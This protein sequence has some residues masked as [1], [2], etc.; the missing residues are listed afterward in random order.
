MNNTKTHAERELDILLKTTPDAIIRDFVPEILA[1][2][3]AFNNSGQSGG[4]APYTAGALSQAIKKLCLYQIIAPLT[5]EDDEWSVS[6]S[7]DVTMQNKRLSSVFKGGDGRAYY[8]NAIVWEGPDEWDTFTGTM[9]RMM[10]RQYIKS[11]PFTPKTF[12]IDVLREDWNEEKHGN[13]EWDRVECGPGPA[14]YQIK[15]REQL[16]EVFEYYDEFLT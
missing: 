11:F 4:S 8:L 7:G 2:C 10:S 16:K 5:G 12:R 13:G 1:V 6:F 3:E 14:A 9:N 15:D